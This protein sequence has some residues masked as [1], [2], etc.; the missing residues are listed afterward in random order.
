[1]GDRAFFA[2]LARFYHDNR[3]RDAGTDDLVK[4]LQPET[5]VP[6]D[7]FFDTWIWSATIPEAHVITQVNADGKTATVRVTSESRPYQIGAPPADFPLTISIQYVD[8]QTEDVTIPV[9]G[10]ATERQVPLKGLVR[11]IVAHD[12]LTLVKLR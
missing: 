8:G 3:F 1:M 6:L 10:G 5:T 12:E 7:R 2:G 4:A 9:I 11:R